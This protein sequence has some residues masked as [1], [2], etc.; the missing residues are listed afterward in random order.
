ML[1]IDGSPLQ[2][3]RHEEAARKMYKCVPAI[4][5]TCT[6]SAPKRACLLWAICMNPS[7][8]VKF[9]VSI[10]EM[11][12][13]WTGG[14]I[15]WVRSRCGVPTIPHFGILHFVEESRGTIAPHQWWLR[16]HE[17]VCDHWFIEIDWDKFYI[18]LWLPS[19]AWNEVNMCALIY[20]PVTVIAW[21]STNQTQGF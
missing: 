5:C 12:K 7:F 14:S 3:I 9:T 15:R 1:L 6:I 20:L 16:S 21:P 4:S 18:N 10:N 17:W 8:G 2:A 11:Y 13:S 19:K